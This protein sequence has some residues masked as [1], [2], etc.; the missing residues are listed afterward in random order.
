MVSYH[1]VFLQKTEV[2]QPSWILHEVQQAYLE[3]SN[4]DCNT[5]MILHLRIEEEGHEQ[6]PE[7]KV[8]TE[9]TDDVD[10]HRMQQ[11]LKVR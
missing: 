11:T 9:M 4:C 2:S 7:T 10:F 3:S 6:P 8:Q 1:T 5:V